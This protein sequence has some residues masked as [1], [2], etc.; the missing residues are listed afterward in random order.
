[1]VENKNITDDDKIEKIV[2]NKI[3]YY[4]YILCI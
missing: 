2:I 3:L 1:M 4:V